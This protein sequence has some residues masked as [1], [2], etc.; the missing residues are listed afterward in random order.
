[1]EETKTRYYKK[2]SQKIKLLGLKNRAVGNLKQFKK[3]VK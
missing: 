1:M 3:S 2:M